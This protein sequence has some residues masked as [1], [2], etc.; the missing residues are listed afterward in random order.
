MSLFMN[1]AYYSCIFIDI[2]NTDICGTRPV[3][4][5]LRIIY[6]EDAMKGEFPWAGFI[7]GEF[8]CSATLLNEFWAVTA[9]HCL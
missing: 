5:D 6:G 3:V 1:N 9:A 4:D 7:D 2:F 8:L